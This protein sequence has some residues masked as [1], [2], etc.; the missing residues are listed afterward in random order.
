[1]TSGFG[2]CGDAAAN[3]GA[4]SIHNWDFREGEAPMIGGLESLES[5]AHA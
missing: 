3:M 2:Q 1:M 5:L 4:K